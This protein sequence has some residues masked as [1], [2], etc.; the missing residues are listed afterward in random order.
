MASTELGR[1]ESLTNRHYLSTKY[2]GLLV[3]DNVPR[4]LVFF[5]VETLLGFWMATFSTYFDIKKI[6]KENI[7]YLS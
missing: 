7:R 1:Q 2:W 5:P 4:G 6:L 3:I